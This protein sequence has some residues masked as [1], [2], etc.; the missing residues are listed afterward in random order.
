MFKFLLGI[1]T[2]VS[3]GFLFAPKKGK[4]LRAN[5]AKSKNK[6]S[7]LQEAVMDASRDASEEIKKI[8]HSKQFLEALHAGKEKIENLADVAKKHGLELSEKAQKEFA[9]IMKEATKK[10]QSSSATLKKTVAKGKKAAGKVVAKGK[11]VIG[12]LKS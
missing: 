4:D 2:G 7:V 1:A 10:A 12:K 5:L 3:L 11:K 6:L 9:V 8:V